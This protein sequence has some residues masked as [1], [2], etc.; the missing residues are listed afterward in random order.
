[1]SSSR[2]LQNLLDQWGSNVESATPPGLASEILRAAPDPGGDIADLKRYLDV[3]G[4]HRFLLALAER[5]DRHL[6]AESAI[7]AISA[8]EYHLRDM[9]ARSARRFPERSLFEDH[10]GSGDPTG[11]SYRFID[12]RLKSIA[13]AFYQLKNEPRVAILASNSVDGACCDLACLMYDILVTPL[14]VHSGQDTL[15]WIFDQLDINIVVTDTIEHFHQ[16]EKIRTELGTKFEILALD[17]LAASDSFPGRAVLELAVPINLRKADAELDRRPRLGFH[18]VA[19]VMFT[20]GSTGLPKGIAFS[21]HNLV[22]KRFCRGAALPNVGEREKLICFLPLFHTFGRYFEMMGMIYWS[23]TYVFPGNPSAATLLALLP[24]VNPTGLISVPVRWQ[25]IH[26]Q[27]VEMSASAVD[28]EQ[29]AAAFRRVVGDRLHWGLSAAGYLAPQVFR[30]F[31]QH[32]VALCSGFGMTEGTGGIT[33]TPPGEYRENSIGLPLPGINVRQVESGELQING[34]YVA[35]Y[36]DD[37]SLGSPR[38]I[39]GPKADDYWLS[40]GD[41][42]K[43]L[44]NGHYEI[45]DRLKDIYKNNRGQTIA[46]QKVEKKF[47][48]VPGIKR[49]FLVGDGRAYNVLLVVPDRDDPLI[50]EFDTPEKLHDYLHQIVGNA[51][52]DLAPYERVVNFAAL[53]RDFTQKDGEL[54]AKG[55]LK[56]KNIETNFHPVI[57]SLYRQPFV[58]H[59][60]GGLTV[61]IPRWLIRDLG[62]LESDI[63]V[64]NHGLFDRY[65]S[66]SLRVETG[67]REGQMVIGDLVYEIKG[68]IL[69][70][71]LIARQP[72]Y[73]LGNAQVISFCPCREGWDVLSDSISSHAQLPTQPTPTA[74]IDSS[75][76][77]HVRD[78]KLHQTNELV[79][80]TFQDDVVLASDAVRELGHRLKAADQRLASLIRLRLEALAWHPEF[81]VRTLAYQILLLDRPTRD[82]GQILPAFIES[83]LPFLDADSIKALATTKLSRRRLEALRQR[84]FG[85]R[86]GLKWPASA[87][88][89]EQFVSI[90]VLLKDFAHYHPEYYDAVRGELAAWILHPDDP[91]ISATAARLFEELHQIYEFRLTEDSIKLSA[92]E[93][94]RLIVFGDDIRTADRERLQKALCGAAFLRQSIMLAFDEHGFDLDQIP[95]QGIWITRIL[96]IRRHRRYRVSI[97]TTSG[98]HFDLQVI[99]SDD[100]REASVLQTIYWLMAISSYPYGHRIL[101]RLGCC[102]EELG[103]WSLVYVGDLTVW[104]KIREFTTNR[105]AAATIPKLQIWRKLLIRGMGAFFRAWRISG[106]RIVPGK[107]APEN[108]VVPDRDFREGSMVA[109]LTEWTPYENTLSLVRPMLQ[110]FI[111]RPGALYPWSREFLKEDWIFDACVHDLGPE[112]ARKFLIQLQDDLSLPD[113]TE[114]ADALSEKLDSFLE[115]LDYEWW[116]PLPVQ[117]A[118]DRFHEWLADTPDGT[119]AAREQIIGELFRLY[120]FDRFS[121]LARYYLNRHTYFYDAPDATRQA[122]DELLEAMFRRSDTPAHHMIELSELQATIED[123]G[124]RRVFAHMVFPRASRPPQFEVVTVG[125][126]STRQV[127]VTTRLTDQFANVYSAR[128]PTEPAEIGQLYRLFFKAGY[129]KTVTDHDLFLVVID[130]DEQIVGGLCYRLEGEEVVHLDGSVIAPGVA[131]RGIGSAL[132]EDFCSRMANEG[133]RVVKT[134]YFMRSF[135]LKRNFRVDQRWGA[136]VRFLQPP[137]LTDTP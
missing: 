94:S 63:E 58:E 45:V 68:T 17:P 108:A 113:A 55:S 7:N 96:A 66:R 132:L 102:R 46:P 20:S 90:L 79:I 23:G 19:T 27:C 78:Q 21:I 31:N 117:N 70:L 54:T 101:P 106:R 83:G 98:R 88:T 97:N 112:Q 42:F 3:T 124:Q 109:S 85:Y 76:L 35:R 33:M 5:A 41:L 52:S 125:D 111:R 93:W 73:W 6:W 53:D 123:E 65:R 103:A 120:R 15:R 38:P 60:V 115:R 10:T 74:A 40:T 105:Q 81:D 30:Y 16:L 75:D 77:R 127:I 56:R 133:Y 4:D 129:P 48:G 67:E 137:R 64:L 130:D 43:L 134:H 50:G 99:L 59:E 1:M 25:Q 47:D 28:R 121:S 95:P 69:D 107:V 12:G 9:F 128:Q 14:N 37:V 29:K 84:L 62:I 136:L 92:E 86:N 104:E 13:A 114:L 110:N 82:Y 87:V 71:G 18:E 116:V 26:E 44:D 119:P 11:F 24:R 51:N 32:G 8:S 80:Q 34:A 89:R 39:S 122:F 135:Y 49:T 61:R 72:A 91:E 22:S 131:G 36:L 126:S 100:V 57:K 2:N 118:V